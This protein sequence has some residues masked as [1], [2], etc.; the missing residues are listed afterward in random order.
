MVLMFF[1]HV[2]QMFLPVGAPDWLTWLGRPVMMMFLFTS[3]E[4]FYYTRSKKSYLWRLLFAAWGMVILSAILQA[5]LPYPVVLMNNAFMTFFVAGVYM[6]LWDRFTIGRQTK[7]TKKIISAILLA[8]VP[9]LTAIPLLVVST[10]EA[11]H[12]T[13]RRVLVFVCMFIP[14]SI[15]LEGGFPVVLLGLLFYALRKWRW[16]QIAAL[17]VLAALEFATNNGSA[18]PWLLILAA[19]PI[20]LYSGEKGRS[21]KWLFY[22]FY[23]A[24]IYVLYII[25]VLT[26]DLFS[27]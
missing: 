6:L 18:K 22:I 9:I 4:S 21:S 26:R 16:A 14:N 5:L 2:H 12:D 10:N 23:P 15:V 20:L 25:A 19:I 17:A 24:H 27:R 3:A 1:D 13:L 11:I 7:N 8:F